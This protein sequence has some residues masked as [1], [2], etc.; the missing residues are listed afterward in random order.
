MTVRVPAGLLRE[1]ANTLVLRN[2]TP[3]ANLGI[4]YILINDIAFT[5]GR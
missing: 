3:G 1:G 4:P 5:D 2:R